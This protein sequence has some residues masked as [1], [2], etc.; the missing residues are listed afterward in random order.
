VLFAT[1]R[2]ASQYLYL[3][4]STFKVRY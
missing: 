1:S 2:S 4:L 3:L